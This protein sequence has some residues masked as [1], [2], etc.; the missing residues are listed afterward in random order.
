M[1]LSSNPNS[2]KSAES[3]SD[4]KNFT[5]STH[6]GFTKKFCILTLYLSKV[7]CFIPAVVAIRDFALCACFFS[8][9][10]KILYAAPFFFHVP[11]STIAS[12]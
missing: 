2:F 12:A 8:R 4:G 10:N 5:G 9:K 6:A 7:Y 1:I 11:F 3:F